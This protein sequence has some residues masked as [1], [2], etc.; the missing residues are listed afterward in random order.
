MKNHNEKQIWKVLQENPKGIGVTQLSVK[1]GVSKQTTINIL[2]KLRGLDEINYPP[3]Q[4][5]KKS[6]ITI[7]H[8]SKNHVFRK[9][10]ITQKAIEKEFEEHWGQPFFIEDICDDLYAG[11]PDD[12]DENMLDF[13]TDMYKLDVNTRKWKKLS[14]PNVPYFEFKKIKKI[15]VLDLGKLGFEQITI[16]DALDLWDKPAHEI[17]RSINCDWPK[18]PHS[19]KCD[20]EIHEIL[21][22]FYRNTQEQLQN[23]YRKKYPNNPDKHKEGFEDFSSKFLKLVKYIINHGGKIPGVNH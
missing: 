14:Y 9:V 2:E 10:R 3:R 22:F 11:I 15:Y 20:H 6:L 1:S 5:G 13:I 23:E 21:G 18:G 19:K 17:Q 4:S 8:V 7:R 16:E 12:A